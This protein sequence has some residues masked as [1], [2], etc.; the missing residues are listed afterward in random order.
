MNKYHPPHKSF[1]IYSQFG[2]KWKTL[3]LGGG[4]GGLVTNQKN[5]GVRISFK[6]YC[7]Y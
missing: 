7:L 1:F 4:E 3:F 5:L 2:N 6:N